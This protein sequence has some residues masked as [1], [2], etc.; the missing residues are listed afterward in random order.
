VWDRSDWSLVQ[1][2]GREVY[3]SNNQLGGIQ[4]MYNNGIS[5]KVEQ[6]DL[7]GIATIL[8]WLSY[9]AKDKMSP[10]PV[11]K[12]V[13]PVERE[14]EFMPTKTPY[15][16]RAMLEGRQSPSEFH[17]KINQAKA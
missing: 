17:N 11:I 9:V 5:H 15:D 13:D 3:A 7:D 1:L 8:K 14:V 12:P 10:L 6:G 2:L 16:P 4:I